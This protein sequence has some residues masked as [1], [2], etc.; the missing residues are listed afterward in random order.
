[1]PSREGSAVPLVSRFKVPGAKGCRFV[2]IPARAVEM[3]A[4]GESGGPARK[5]KG[6]RPGSGKLCGVCRPASTRDAKTALSE[7]GDW[8]I[9]YLGIDESAR[10]ELQPDMASVLTINEKTDEMRERNGKYVLSG[11]VSVAMDSGKSGARAPVEVGETGSGLD[12]G[13]SDPPACPSSTYCLLPASSYEV[14]LAACGLSGGKGVSISEIR[15]EGSVLCACGPRGIGGS[16]P[17]ESSSSLF[18]AANALCLLSA[19][20]I[21]HATPSKEH[22]ATRVEQATIAAKAPD[23]RCAVAGDV[24]KG[25]WFPGG[26]GT[27]D[28]SDV[29]LCPVVDNEGGL[30]TRVGVDTE[31]PTSVVPGAVGNIGVGSVVGTSIDT[32]FVVVENCVSA[33]NVVISVVVSMGVVRSWVRQTS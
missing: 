16:E 2:E 12:T 28:G 31:V 26:C 25:D 3:T 5:A 19:V 27:D 18:C 22:S 21:S 20:R 24:V 33:G 9:I 23:G 30:E 13:T 15:W 11:A 4:P 17:P 7:E 1:M 29:E 6:S 32:S 8:R 14:Q 10:L